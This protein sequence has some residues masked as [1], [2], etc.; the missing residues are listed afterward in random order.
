M[1]QIDQCHR[2]I[3]SI[4]SCHQLIVRVRPRLLPIWNEE[5]EFSNQ[6]AAAHDDDEDDDDDDGTKTQTLW[7]EQPGVSCPA[8]AKPLHAGCVV[9]LAFE[10]TKLGVY[11]GSCC[12]CYDY[13]Y[14]VAPTG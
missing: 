3:Y 14:D 12:Y 1:M 13:E 6:N 10:Y 5:E 4:S 2:S 9:V 7:T 11:G 8:A